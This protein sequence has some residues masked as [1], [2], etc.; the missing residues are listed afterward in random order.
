[1]TCWSCLCTQ[2]TQKSDFDGGIFD[3]EWISL[4]SASDEEIAPMA[5]NLNFNDI[6]EYM[7]PNVTEFPENC[8]CTRSAQLAS[9][10]LYIS[11]NSVFIY[12][13]STLSRDMR[14]LMEW[15]RINIE[16]LRHEYWM[17][18]WV[19]ATSSD[20]RALPWCRRDGRRFEE[21]SNLNST[22]SSFG[23]TRLWILF[24]VRPPLSFSG[25][26]FLIILLFCS[27]LAPLRCEQKSVVDHL[28]FFPAVGCPEG[29]TSVNMADLG[30]ECLIVKDG[31]EKAA[32]RLD[33]R[34]FAALQGATTEWSKMEGFSY[35]ALRR[36]AYVAMSDIREGMED[37]MR[38]GDEDDR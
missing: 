1:M 28:V 11:N 20:S 13:T 32:S 18:G 3:L 12:A 7:A 14:N 38:K 24:P 34:R 10:L 2:V 6:F 35:S 37:N 21:P 16:M 33:T 5:S 36:R 26:C 4:G 22:F 25:P 31:M 29:F 15:S 27:W 8:T 23:I 19:A 9:T 17:L 30:H